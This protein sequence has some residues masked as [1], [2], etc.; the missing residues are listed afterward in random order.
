MMPG[1]GDEEPG[2]SSPQ[3]LPPGF[4][5]NDRRQPAYAPYSAEFDEVVHLLGR[6][7]K[8]ENLMISGDFTCL[9][10]DGVDRLTARLTGAPL[11]LEPLLQT[12]EDVVKDLGL[13]MPG[14]SA[15]DLATAIV[16]AVEKSD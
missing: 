2:S 4:G 9:P 11:V 15:F 14:V 8:I 7:G 12:I 13:Q 1:A 6:D 16:A 10:P 5:A 3:N